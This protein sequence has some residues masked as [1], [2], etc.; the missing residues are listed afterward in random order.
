MTDRID[1]HIRRIEKRNQRVRV[2]Q[3]L[4]VN[5]KTRAPSTSELIPHLERWA[6]QADLLADR[7]KAGQ[8]VIYPHQIAPL[9]SELRRKS[10]PHIEPL[11]AA[12]EQ[13][14]ID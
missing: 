12:V 13:A 4:A 5:L 14:F 3:A 1:E 2:L 9:L 8:P 11:I 7:T 6:A 10:L